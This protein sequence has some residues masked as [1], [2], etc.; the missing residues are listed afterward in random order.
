MWIELTCPVGSVEALARA[1]LVT[2]HCNRHLVGRGEDAPGGA[3]P[4]DKGII[5]V[6]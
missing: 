2:A 5:L 1:I 4:G 3:V 6:I